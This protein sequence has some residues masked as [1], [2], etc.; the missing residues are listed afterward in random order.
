M[1]KKRIK[2]F[3]IHKICNSGQCF[4]LIPIGGN[5]YSLIAFGEY[6][7]VEQEGGEVSFSCTEQEFEDRWSAYFDPDTD[8]GAIEL[9]VDASDAYLTEAVRCGSGMRIL[10]QDLW[11]VIVSFIISQQNNIPRI[12]KCVDAL[13]R[14]FGGRRVNFRG[15]EYH[16]FPAAE[17]LARHPLEDFSVCS[18]GYRA[19]YIWKTAQMVSGGEVS[20]SE[21]GKMDYE[22]ARAEL[23]KLCGVGIK[24]AECI[25]LFALHHV[26]AFPIDT[27][28]QDMLANH[29][30]EGF[31]FE[32]YRG[33]AGILQQYGFYYELWGKR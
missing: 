20:L 31:P 25:C 16:T 1:I 29:Y 21:I 28:I 27:H 19:K 18:L 15:D 14:N 24:V 6:L 10:R 5:R 7:E 3:D 4:R 23:M 13:C 17:E 9:S 2:N 26:D 12:R 22:T 33:Y 11:E 8:Y 32:R 30:P